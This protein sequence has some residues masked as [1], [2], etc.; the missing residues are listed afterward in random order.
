MSRTGLPPRLAAAF[1]LGVLPLAPLSAPAQAFEVLVPQN[2]R[3]ISLVV[4]TGQLI[5]VDGDFA[6][7]FVANPDV[8]DIQVR[9]SRMLYLTGVGV[10]ETTLFAL[11]ETDNVLMS[12]NVRVTHN[13]QAL[14]QGLSRVA[15]GQ[16]VQA[17]SVD[18]SLVITGTVA[19]PEQADNVLQVAHQFV[20]DP[21]RVINRM[22]IA[23]PT[24]VNL[25]VRIAEVSRNVDRQLGIR[26]NELSYGLGAGSRIGFVGG[27]G[28]GDS[29]GSFGAGYQRSGRLNV[30]VVLEALSEEGLVA[31]LAEPNLTARSGEPASFLAGGEFPYPVAQDSGSVGIEFKQFG[32]QLNFTPTVIDGDQISLKVG[33]EVSD[34]SFTGGSNI[35]SLSTRRA[36]TT[37]DLGSGQSFAI[38]GL[39]QNSSATTANKM[40]GLGSIPVLGALFR[41]SGFQRGQTELVI[42]VTP[43]VV[44]PTSAARLRTPVDHYLPPN[45]FERILFGRVQGDPARVTAVQNRI[46]NR[47]LQ[48]AAG[49]IYE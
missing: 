37:V 46:G 49:F 28:A 24:Q 23:Q 30:D 14:Q 18:R 5:R 17:T 8:A 43:V 21:L 13:T 20:D 45:D 16:S 12:S 35:P 7:L 10:G 44:S 11:D 33:T 6:S 26:W 25:Q 48:G 9:S 22:S 32:I 42:I 4:G 40:P 38:A 3:S 19:S 39:I 15:P 29:P 27:R 41:S 31:V 34:L 36:E 2:E 1:L 47:R